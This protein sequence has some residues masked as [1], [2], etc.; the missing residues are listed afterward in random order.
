LRESVDV[1]YRGSFG[2]VFGD[3]VL[4]YVIPNFLEL[5]LRE[6]AKGGNEPERHWDGIGLSRHE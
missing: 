4:S 1:E 2:T 3:D 5:V 6:N